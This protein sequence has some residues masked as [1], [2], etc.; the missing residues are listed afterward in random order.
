MIAECKTCSKKPHAQD[1]I[2]GRGKR[3]LNFVREEKDGRL[4]HR[5]TVCGSESIVGKEQK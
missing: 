1:Q 5:C 4:S 3:V 2:H